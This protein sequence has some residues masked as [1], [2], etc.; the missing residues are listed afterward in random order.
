MNSSSIAPGLRTIYT[1]VPHRGYLRWNWSQPICLSA[2]GSCPR[3]LL[4]IP[5]T[6]YRWN[7][8][9]HD[10]QVLALWLSNAAVLAERSHEVAGGSN[11]I[12]SAL[13]EAMASDS[14]VLT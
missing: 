4:G 12:V 5:T 11:P 14:A 13:T 8:E 3:P 1:E 2:P 9:R 6:G 7:F 10:Q